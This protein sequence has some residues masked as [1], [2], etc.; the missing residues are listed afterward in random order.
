[1]SKKEIHMDVL[2]RKF[3]CHNDKTCLS[4]HTLAAQSQMRSDNQ[5]CDACITLDD[6]TTIQVHRIIM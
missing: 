4:Q 2:D 3:D 1:M 5:L 6:G